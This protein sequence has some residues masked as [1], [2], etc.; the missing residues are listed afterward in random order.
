M[1]ISL[2]KSLLFG[3]CFTFFVRPAT[4]LYGNQVVYDGRHHYPD[5]Q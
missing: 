2:L 1:V 3:A 4:L 5:Q